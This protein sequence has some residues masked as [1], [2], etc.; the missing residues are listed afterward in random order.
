MKKLLVV[1]VLLAGVTAARCG[2]QFKGVFIQQHETTIDLD[3]SPKA[4]T[5]SALELEYLVRTLSSARETLKPLVD[6]TT[7]P[8]IVVTFSPTEVT[9]WHPQ[10]SPDI[11]G[12][13]IPGETLLL[14]RH[15]GFGWMRLSFPK[16]E[17][18]KIGEYLV[19]QSKD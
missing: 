10:P 6:P 13:A 12:I 1:L 17:A 9:A 8:H 7:P 3:F 18:R 16:E 14:L 19:E 5:L 4:S 15:P 2:E 11:P